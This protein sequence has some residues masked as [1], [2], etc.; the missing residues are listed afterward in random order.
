MRIS[1]SL[2]IVFLLLNLSATFSQTMTWEEKRDFSDSIN[3]IKIWT[4]IKDDPGYRFFTEIMEDLTYVLAKKGYDVIEIH[5]DT[6]NIMTPADWLQVQLLSL[7]KGEA[8]LTFPVTFSNDSVIRNK[9]LQR[10]NQTVTNQQGG[11]IVSGQI[12]RYYDQQDT[13]FYI[14][15][16]VTC[17]TN[18]RK[19]REGSFAPVYSREFSLDRPDVASL[20]NKCL[21]GIPK[22]RISIVSSPVDR[23]V[24]RE[25]VPVEITGYGGFFFPSSRTTEKGSASFAAN[26]Q[27]GVSLGFGMTKSVDFLL[28]FRRTSTGVT[29]HI[30]DYADSSAVKFNTSYITLGAAYNF[31]IKPWVS[32][33]MGLSLGAVNLSPRG[34]YYREVWYFALIGEAGSKFYLNPWLGLLIQADFFYQVHPKHAPFLYAPNTPVGIDDALS[35]MLQIGISAGV[36]FRL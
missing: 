20:I 10:N 29:M 33:Y 13:L 16:Q 34:D 27:Y 15:A 24:F 22:C 25:K 11:A 6:S 32:P 8:L 23:P 12:N 1:F 31:R 4:Y 36:I 30:P 28:S 9:G 19:T 2:P 3:T 26:A 18:Y 17:Y 35:N 21:G 7:Q 14:G 5:Y